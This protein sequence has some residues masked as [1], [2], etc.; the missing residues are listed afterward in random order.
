[1]DNQPINVNEEASLNYWVSALDCS[2]LE[3][4]VAVAE[5]GPSVKD[6]SNELGRVL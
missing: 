3:L 5:V 1:M 2:E 4:R 6:V